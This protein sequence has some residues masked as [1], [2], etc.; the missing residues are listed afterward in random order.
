M[1][2][3][4][5]GI[6]AILFL[7]R[8]AMAVQFQS[9]GA[10]APLISSKL[11]FS[12]ADIGILI[13]LYF[14]PG[15]A[16]ALP[17][18][19]I[20]QR[21]GDRTTAIGALALMLVGGML[22]ALAPSWSLQVAGRLAAGTGGIVVGVVLT[23]MV[24]DWFAGREIATAMAIFVASWPVGIAI[25]L[26]VLPTLGTSLGV[27]AVHLGVAGFTAGCILLLAVCYRPVAVAQ[28]QAESQRLDLGVVLALVASGLVWGL[29][30]IGFAMIF[31][32]GPSMLVEQGWSIAAAGSAISI[33]LWFTAVSGP[34]GGVLADQ[35]RRPQLII[36]ASCAAFGLL[37]FVWPRTGAVLLTIAALGAVSGFPVGAIL[38]LPATVL[39]PGTR[40]IGMGLF[41]T[42]LSACMM[43]GT[44][45]AGA[46]AGWA[47]SASAAIDFGAAM[48]LACPLLVWLFNRIS[49]AVVRPV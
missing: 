28:T 37:L 29:F 42:V 34:L 44:A 1:L 26:L 11:G 3:N 9:V 39:H 25:A 47:G 6:L 21:F 22:M 46:I 41:F 17:G 36:V 4:R 33:V 5:W 35:L 19:A 16:L 10:V 38:S 18:G 31:S 15:I 20:G 12:I 49:S 45:V 2:R 30:N 32:F 27:G 13:G 48:V 40:A 24:T 23:K 14:A 8:A 43:L 7:A